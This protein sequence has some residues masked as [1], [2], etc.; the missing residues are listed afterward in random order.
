M[1]DALPR[2]PLVAGTGFLIHP[3][4]FA[5]TARHV[6]DDANQLA[7]STGGALRAG[8]AIPELTG[9]VTIRA[10]FEHV[11]L[12]V[13]EVDPRHDLALVKLDPNPFA[14]GKAS[15]VAR[16]PEGGIVVN[17]QYGLA[18]LWG[19]VPRDG[20]S[21]AVS[22][23]PTVAPALVTT[24]GIVASATALD[25]VETEVPGAPEGFTFPDA[26]DSYL[27][28][29][30]VNPGNSGGPA[31]LV[32]EAAVIGVCV[33]FRPVGQP[34]FMYNSG[35]SIAVPVKYGVELLARHAQL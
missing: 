11:K 6:V 1:A 29:V 20:D 5:L 22:G 24:H 30:A 17:A 33:A 16:S 12:D 27:L 13:V 25:V 10:S 3:E 14:S 26:R 8:L 31:Y 35:I 32:Y 2:K 4:G 28:D 9:N 23:Y 21:V 15:G 18:T 34:P 19:G 7:T